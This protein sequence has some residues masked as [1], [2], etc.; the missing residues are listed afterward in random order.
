MPPKDYLIQWLK[1]IGLDNYVIPLPVYSID[2]SCQIYVQE[3]CSK[4][5]CSERNNMWRIEGV[6]TKVKSI[7]EIICMKVSMSYWR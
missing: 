4:F 5:C 1:H 2:S 6:L 7:Q 3:N